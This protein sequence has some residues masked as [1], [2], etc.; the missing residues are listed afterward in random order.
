MK[1]IILSIL[2]YFN[3]KKIT[4]I[5]VVEKKNFKDIEVLFKKVIKKLPKKL[6]NGF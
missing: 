5:K 1:S 3:R 2:I 6:S 4:N